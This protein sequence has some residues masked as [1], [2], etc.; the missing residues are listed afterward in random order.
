M[1]TWYQTLPNLS[2]PTMTRTAPAAG[3]ATSGATSAGTY[4]AA[5]SSLSP[6]LTQPS[7]PPPLAIL[8]SPYPPYP[9][10]ASLKTFRTCNA[11]PTHY[12]ETAWR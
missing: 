10:A 8:S 7:A 6:P 3:A 11:V 4:D 9:S 1:F 5:S 2:D 12:G